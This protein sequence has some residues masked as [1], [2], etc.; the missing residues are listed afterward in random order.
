MSR[1]NTLYHGELSSLIDELEAGQPCDMQELT[2][3]V[4]NLARHIERMDRNQRGPRLHPV[5]CTCDRC[6]GSTSHNRG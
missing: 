5:T 2:A 6:N 4:T 1:F 3:V